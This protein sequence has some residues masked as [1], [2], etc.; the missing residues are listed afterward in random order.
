MASQCL[1][2]GR[3]EAGWTRPVRGGHFSMVEDGDSG[4]RRDPAEEA[5]AAAAA[6]VTRRKTAR[7]VIQVT[8]LRVIDGGG[9]DAKKEDAREERDGLRWRRRGR[10]R[11]RQYVM[12]P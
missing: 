12:F 3:G 8:A 2:L 10:S 6:A 9:C 5:T 1:K 7:Y 11:P 4:R